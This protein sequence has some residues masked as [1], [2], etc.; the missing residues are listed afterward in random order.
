MQMDL[1]L[2]N[3]HVLITGASRGIG[4]AIAKQFLD[5]GAYVSIVGRTMTSLE[6]AK[7]D[8]GNIDIFDPETN[9]KIG[10]WYL[11]KLYKQFGDLDFT[12]PK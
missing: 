11:N 4:K 6:Q 1:G 2:A 10:C 7:S 3:K 8:L 12:S 9:I 5:E